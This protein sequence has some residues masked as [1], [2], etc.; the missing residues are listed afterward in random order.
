MIANTLYT[1][2]VLVVKSYYRGSTNSFAGTQ[3]LS[4]IA[5][6]SLKP[7]CAYG[8]WTL[9]LESDLALLAFPQHTGSI[10]HGIISLMRVPGTSNS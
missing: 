7:F 6:C 2:Y 3:Y 1:S 9:I 10:D 5:K 8:F 4:T